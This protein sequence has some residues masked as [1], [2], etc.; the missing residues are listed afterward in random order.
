M[1]IKFFLKK[2]YLL[3]AL[4]GYT[5]I[6]AG[7][8]NVNIFDKKWGKA[9]EYLFD[10]ELLLLSKTLAELAEITANKQSTQ[11][12]KLA[13]LTGEYWYAKNNWL[14]AKKY[15]ETA[16]LLLEKDTSTHLILAEAYLVAGFTA[17]SLKDNAQTL[18]YYQKAL[19]LK[20]KLL[21]EKH[22]RVAS[23]YFNI[24]EV[25][26]AEL[27][28][29]ESDNAFQKGVT[30]LEAISIEEE[31][32][33]IDYYEELAFNQSLKYDFKAAIKYLKKAVLLKEKKLGEKHY[34]LVFPYKYL[35]KVY[36]DIEYFGE[37]ISYYNKALQIS[38]EQEKRD[39]YQEAMLRFHIGKSYLKLKNY[40]KAFAY[41]DQAIATDKTI[42]FILYAS[43]RSRGQAE[44][45]KGN[46]DEANKHFDI[47]LKG[48]TKIA[49]NNED[50]LI[51]TYK[52]VAK[53]QLKIGEY[54]AALDNVQ[55]AITKGLAIYES[56][57]H[58]F[59]DLYVLLGKCHLAL[60]DRTKAKLWISKAK[61]I[62]GGSVDLELAN[63][64]QLKNEVI[65]NLEYVKLYFAYKSEIRALP[66]L[67]KADSLL[68][69]TI[70]L[71]DY[72]TR[73][74]QEKST[75]ENF[76]EEYHRV[77][78]K[79]IDIKYSLYNIT[80][81]EQYLN[82]AFILSEKSKNLILLETLNNVDA[83]ELAV[84]PD[85][86][87][88]KEQSLRMDITFLE[89][90]RYEEHQKAIL[91]DITIRTLNGQIFELKQQYQTLLNKIEATYP[92]YFQLKFQSTFVSVF[93]IQNNILATDQTIIEYFLGDDWIYV[94]LIKKADFKVLRLPKAKD[95][96][97]KINQFRESIYSYRL[98][99]VNQQKLLNKSLVSTTNQLGEELYELLIQ[100]FQNELT[101]K[102]IIVADGAL[103][104]LPFDA[105]IKKSQE[106]TGP[107]NTPH[108]L[109]TDYMISYAHSI[110]WL[111]DLFKEEKINF[112]QN[113]VGIAPE[114]QATA[115][116]QAI[117]DFRLGL[118][119]LQHNQTEVEVIKT[120]IGGKI[121]TGV[122]ATRQAF[123][124]YLA[125]GQI[126]HLATHGKS[127]DEQGDYSY[128]AFAKP[129]D[130][131]DNQFLYVK[132]LFNLKIPA[133]LVVLSACETG[134]G[135][136][137]R[138]EGIVGIGKGFSYAGAK[139]MVT[140]LWRVSDNSTANFMP[141]FYEN[142]K[143][144]QAKDEALW[145]AKKQFIDTYRSA[146]HP[147]FWS[148]YVAYG[149]MEPINFQHI[150]WS[151]SSLL[152]LGLVGFFML[153]LIS[154]FFKKAKDNK[155]F[156]SFG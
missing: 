126:L 58:F 122:A 19:L 141:I 116:S 76:I 78:K 47:A 114:F 94:F 103:G 102:V 148:G 7:Q 124:A 43:H 150:N 13:Y 61:K 97:T 112:A 128:L 127:N 155:A 151:I 34:S 91:N 84:I 111:S 35:G 11:Y 44:S 85:T 121:I 60:E 131:T 73:T 50:Y 88:Q 69:E 37:A 86:I 40:D 95:L 8:D 29:I 24:G 54:Q 89:N 133:E 93:H 87:L 140:T 142:L 149:N 154:Y 33:L 117:A 108:Y 57:P 107:S 137:K 74:Y 68:A 62:N 4:L 30:I 5:L 119:P 9:Q 118:G 138:G 45:E 2:V 144:G 79:A 31:I 72:I 36:Y 25:Y 65:L 136:I 139:S 83:L 152:G 70:Q 1:G 14:K 134:L 153:F 113:F 98:A 101:K 80:Q 32:E 104:Y 49:K 135:E 106:E 20:Q 17:E 146:G 18:F 6:G 63:L 109:M 51:E 123:L 28:V 64:K 26:Q 105:L 100:P 27:K 3:C 145:N 120:D 147:F 75:K 15:L 22:P 46:I 59:F 132:D 115:D 41:F 143:K 129:R 99:T 81:K 10:E 82:T 48:F 53:H 23:I 96:I 77:F 12:G 55:I 67:L 52:L 110:N 21:G 39:V 92:D 130:T 66:A 156:R 16:I 38:I 71:V 125:Q 90:R 56:M 42:D